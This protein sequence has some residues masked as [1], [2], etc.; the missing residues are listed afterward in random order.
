M[1]INNVALVVASCLNYSRLEKN[2]DCNNQENNILRSR[3][4][5]WTH[6]LHFARKKLY[7]NYENTC[8]EPYHFER[9][10]IIPL[11]LHKVA[12][13]NHIPDL[14]DMLLQGIFN[15]REVKE[16]DHYKLLV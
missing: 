9:N 10:L 15:S 11:L 8:K 3:N 1:N 16:L 7:S 5:D 12:I 6:A 14:K 4:I 13:I 2:Y